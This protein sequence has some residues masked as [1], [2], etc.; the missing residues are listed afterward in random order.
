[1]ATKKELDN[2]IQGYTEINKLLN[3]ELDA[4]K[5]L[6]D[7]NVI[8]AKNAEIVAERQRLINELMQN[9]NNLTDEQRKK[10][11]ELRQENDEQIRQEK[12]IAEGLKKQVEHRQKILKGVKEITKATIELRNHLLTQDKIIKSTILNLGMSGQKAELMRKSFEQSAQEVIMLGG[13][14]EDI[15]K[16]QQGFA[17]ET[18]KARALTASMVKDVAAIGK[19]TG[20]GIEN[21]TKLAA[22]FE[23]MGIDVKNTMTWTQGVVDTTERMGINTTKVLKNVSDNFRK[24][25]T[26]TFKNGVKAFGQMAIDA[27]RTRVSMETALNVAEATRSLENV[28]ELGANLQVMGGNFAKMD[29]FHWLFMVRNEPEKLNVELSKMT[30]GMFTLKKNSDGVFEKFISPADADRLRNV[31]K[32]L[33]ISNE[34]MFEIAQRRMDLNEVAKQ[35]SGIGLTADQKKVIEGAATLNQTTGKYQ[36]MLAGEMKDISDLT[37]TQANAFQSEQ[38]LLKDRAR[39]AQTF[40][41]VFKNTINAMKAGLLPLLNNINKLLD[42]VRPIFEWFANS[43]T[44]GGAIAKLLLAGTILK[45][46]A[47]LLNNAAS[48]ILK[49]K[50]FRKGSGAGAVGNTPMSGS[51]A[52]GTGKGKMYSG[53]GKMMAGAGLGVA[54]VGIGAGVAIAATGISAL[55]DAMSKLTPEQGEIL[56]SI[57]N[58]L[59]I[60]T[61]IAV[62]LSVGIAALG[63]TATAASLGL[64]AFGGAVFLVG[65][66]VAIAATGIG[67]MVGKLTQLLENTKGAGDDMMGMARGMATMAG[68]MALFGAGALGL[69][70]FASTMKTIRKSSDELE[71]VGLSFERMGTAVTQL[72]G[73]KDDLISVKNALEGI[74]KANNIKNGIFGEIANLMN[75]P[76]KVE[77]ANNGKIQLVN[78]VTLNIDSEK[79]MNRIYKV[80]LAASKTI[81]AKSGL[82]GA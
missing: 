43:N 55:A 39:E 45:G 51:Q 60:F 26:F 67:F 79:F 8:R 22:Q 46:G 18:G 34:E 73:S 76:L 75:K 35:L 2:T 29:P 23:F 64:V 49:T 78:D 30:T 77:W 25:S 81:G 58:S 12:I 40:D 82:S 48:N 52:L 71:T 24:L 27:E 42:R 53:K 62:G 19:G 20:L 10:L 21:A 54:A 6:N 66:G 7:I 32:S 80:D 50:V 65:S 5:A 37:A 1:M 4:A 31:A 13:N 28:I 61:G 33:G 11:Q 17:D 41:E 74:S 14:L 72:T 16:I 36:V 57:V 69:P 47:M 59:L 70:V 68:S 44:T 3:S 56:K 63:A 15:G 9:I 38:L